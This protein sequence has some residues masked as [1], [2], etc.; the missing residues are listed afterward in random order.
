[1]LATRCG[2]GMSE[3]VVTEAGFGSDLGGE[4]FLNIVCPQLGKLPDAMV[5]VAS[6]RALKH[7]GDGDL[8]SGLANLGRHI[9]HLEQYGP[10]VVVTVNRF[11]GDESADID[12]VC[13][14]ARAQGCEAVVSNAWEK[15]GEGCAELAAAVR[16]AART[17]SSFETMYQWSDSIP[18][19]L[20]K[21]AKKVYGA[22]GIELS[23]V[24]QKELVWAE[25]HGFG[26]LPV[27]VAKTQY[28]LSDDA[29]KLG[30]P[31]DFTLHVR[32]LKVSA[33]AGFIVAI[34]GD[35]LL[36]PGMGKDP[37]ARHILVDEEGI[38]HG[39]Y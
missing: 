21:L 16:D 1:M 7:H 20:E 23:R 13:Q 35:I 24:A 8:G 32:E 27:C 17:E 37:A 6:V 9:E 4:K 2:L 12:A 10:P 19:K 26:E 22:S 14:Y 33:G 5:L 34:C 28:S 31:K 15:G 25:K 38:V 39:L 3:F 36:M 30:A 18:A 11:A 29:K